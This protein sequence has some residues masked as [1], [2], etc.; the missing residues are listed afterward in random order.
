MECVEIRTSVAMDTC[1][2]T[3]VSVL[4]MLEVDTI[5]EYGA[6]EMCMRNIVLW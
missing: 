3:K 4:A 2:P 1:L 5:Y 6:A